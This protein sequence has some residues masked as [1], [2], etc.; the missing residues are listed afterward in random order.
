MSIFQRLCGIREQHFHLLRRFHIILSSFISHTVF[1]CQLLSCLKTQQNIMRLGILRQSVMHV[2]CHYQIDPCFFVHF[3]KLLI[4]SLLLRNPMILHFQKEISLSKN[5]LIPKCGSFCILVHSSCKIFGHLACQAGAESNNSLM[6]LFQNLNIYPGFIIKAFYKAF[7]NN[8]HQIAVALIIFCKKHQM[9]ITVLT[10]SCFSV[11]PGPR[12]HINL[13]AQN[14]ID[15]CC[16]CSPVKINHSIHNAMIRNS[17]TVHPQL[18]YTGH[19]F[20]DLIGTV[21]KTVFCMNM[22]MCKIHNLLLISLSD[23]SSGL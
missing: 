8:L 3:K 5:I 21:Q 7:G 18:F 22:K 4:Y 16:L 2:I 13:A 1:I 10:T 14:G 17:R 9:I 12:R 11:E 19:I 6:V 23:K 20:L 15:P